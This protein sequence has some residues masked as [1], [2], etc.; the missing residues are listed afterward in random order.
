MITELLILAAIAG[1]AVDDWCGTPHPHPWP[2][3]RKILALIGGGG[4]YVIFGKGL[5]ATDIV[6]TVVLGG[7]GGVFLASLGGL[8]LGRTAAVRT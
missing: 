2:W 7:V 8:V 1:W 6:T 3:L 5:A 4:A